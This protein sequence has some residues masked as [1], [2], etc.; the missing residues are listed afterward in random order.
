M[1]MCDTCGTQTP[2]EHYEKLM[3]QDLGPR[4]EAVV[5]SA[6]SAKAVVAAREAL[7]AIERVRIHPHHEMVPVSTTLLRRAAIL[8]NDLA[9]AARFERMRLAALQ[10]CVPHNWPLVSQCHR[11]LAR[12]LGTQARQA[13]QNMPPAVWAKLA[14]QYK[15]SSHKHAR[16]AAAM[17][18][19]CFGQARTAADDAGEATAE[20]AAS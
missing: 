1:C 17:E 13:P 4:L 18:R 20:A 2:F 5:T 8:G 3:D 11:A 6:D 10:A 19:I 14:E 7:N 9:L 12:L 16:E 15:E